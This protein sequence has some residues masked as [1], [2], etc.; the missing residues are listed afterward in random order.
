MAVKKKILT[1][2]EQ[3]QASIDYNKQVAAQ[4]AVDNAPKPPLTDKGNLNSKDI[5]EMKNNQNSNQRAAAADMNTVNN[6]NKNSSPIIQDTQ[7]QIPQAENIPIQTS[8]R[9]EGI[10]GYINPATAGLSALENSGLGQAIQV[11]GQLK[12]NPETLK[13]LSNYTAMMKKTG[14]TPEQV[15]PDPVMQRLLNLQLN[16]MDVQNLEAGNA[17]VSTLGQLIEG[18][19]VLG[20]VNARYLGIGNT[21]SA[22]VQTMM[23][24]MGDLQK[25]IDDASANA[26]ANPSMTNAY[27]N[28][29]KEAESKVLQLE[30]K[31]KLMTIQSPD[32]QSDPEQVI[33]IMTK[34]SNMKESILA[35]KNKLLI[36]QQS[37]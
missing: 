9:D 1:P 24:T 2:Q 31:I 29:V 10:M 37:I 13:S 7:T 15:S 19:P 25:S 23:T 20:R 22:Q 8:K 27:I 4:H 3:A 17:Q 21:P 16:E 28:Q 5:I 11:S 26:A 35:S 30:S 32:L 12:Q 33:S 36:L 6:T 34:I 18:L 14:L